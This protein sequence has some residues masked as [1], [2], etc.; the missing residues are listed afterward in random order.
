VNAVDTELPPKDHN[1]DTVIIGELLDE[2]LPIDHAELLERRDQLIDA[3][4]R[5]PAITDDESAAK[6]SDYIDLLAGL[7]AANKKTHEQVKAPY[8]AASKQIDDFFFRGVRDP[9]TEVWNRAKAKLKAYIDAKAAAERKARE[10]AERK[11]REE[12]TRLAREAEE[13]A[14]KAQTEQDLQKAI[15]VEEQAQAA[16][17]AVVAARQEATVKTSELASVKGTVGRAKS[18]K[19]FWDFRDIDRAS[20]DLEALRP[21]LPLDGIETAMRAFIKAGGRDIKGATI[22][23]N[24]RL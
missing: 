23:E 14:R 22:F 19:T 10:E 12:A 5:M 8:L 18:L 2:T 11:A 15:Q 17:V 1:Q 24:T 21:Y 9:V 6:V 3:E 7:V 16:Q 13:A 4:D 20:L